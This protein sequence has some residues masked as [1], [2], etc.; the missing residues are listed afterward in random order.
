LNKKLKG[1][2][3]DKMNEY[4]VIGFNN[5]YSICYFNALIQCLIS[6]KQFRKFIFKQDISENINSKNIEYINKFKNFFNNP[7]PN[8]PTMLLQDMDLLY[9]NE[10]SLEYLGIL[11]EKLNCEDLFKHER[12][13]EL[14]CPICGFCTNM[15][16]IANYSEIKT[17]F[18]SSFKTNNTKCDKCKNTVDKECISKLYSFSN[19]FALYKD[20]NIKYPVDFSIKTSKGKINY[21]LCGLIVHFD[22]GITSE[23][24]GSNSGH[25][26]SIVKDSFNENKWYSIDDSIVKSYDV[27]SGDAPFH[28]DV[29]ILFYEKV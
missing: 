25:Y 10:C 7:E 21:K 2:Q 8:F 18:G 19:I 6:L 20:K 24:R 27:I 22:K 26:I 12:I 23:N 3:F 9:P 29:F 16:D 14:K 11:I 17:C 1:F 13:I 28:D 15:K 4:R 5:N